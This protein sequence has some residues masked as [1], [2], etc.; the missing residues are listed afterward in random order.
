LAPWILF[1]LW[2]LCLRSLVS[3]SQ[4][5]RCFELTR[6]VSEALLCELQHKIKC[7]SLLHCLYWSKLHW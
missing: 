7:H 6:L 4:G 1:S 5:S 2:T 3:L